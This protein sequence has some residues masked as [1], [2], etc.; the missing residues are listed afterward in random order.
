M[1]RN[2]N[3]DPFSQYLLRFNC[4]SK[5]IYIEIHPISIYIDNIL[6]FTRLCSF[7]FNLRI[8]L[9]AAI[10]LLFAAICFDVEWLWYDFD[11]N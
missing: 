11:S 7:Q 8:L 9:L 2:E 4:K 6:S 5:Y 1:V 3:D 10:L